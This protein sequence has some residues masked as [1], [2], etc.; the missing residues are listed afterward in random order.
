MLTVID[1][2]AGVVRTAQGVYPLATA[3][4]FAA[5]SRAWLRCGWDTKHV[6][7]FTWMGRPI[8]QLPE[9][10]IRVQEVIYAVQPDVII[11]TGVA[12]G[13]GQVFFASLCKAMD[14]GRVI[15]V[16]S[17]LRPHNRAALQAHLL[18]PL[19]TLIDG[20]SIDPAT[21][22]AVRAQ[23]HPGECVLVVLDSAHSKAHVQ[24]ELELYAPLVSVG[25]YLIAADGIMSELAGAPRTQ[26]DWGWNNP[27]TAVRE[28]L[29]A[30]PNQFVCTSPPF[31]FNEGI[32]TQP[33]TY[34]IDGYLKRI[35]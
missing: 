20:S 30:H 2:D 28:F 29:A 27:R 32:V 1:E 17:A 26:A 14:H 18:A 13:G 16:E 35:A 33:V 7:S 4:A 34:W 11:E 6:Y 12:H 19:I 23:I 10:L 9:D 24:Q 31:L 5:V 15:G 22:A 3:E 8:I 25:S 21:V